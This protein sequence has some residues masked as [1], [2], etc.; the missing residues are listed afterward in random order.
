MT[1][2][3]RILREG[4][5]F[6]GVDTIESSGFGVQGQWVGDTGREEGFVNLGKLLQLNRNRWFKRALKVSTRGT[7]VVYL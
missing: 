1:V 3:K 4:T 7:Q 2:P 5:R 6:S